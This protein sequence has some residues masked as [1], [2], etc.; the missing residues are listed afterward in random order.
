MEVVTVE[1]DTGQRVSCTGV[2]VGC[3]GKPLFGYSVELH[4]LNGPEHIK[5]QLGIMT[6]LREN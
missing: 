4:L 3:K 1:S 2:I 5:Q 6:S